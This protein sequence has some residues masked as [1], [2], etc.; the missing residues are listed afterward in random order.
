MELQADTGRNGIVREEF[1]ELNATEAERWQVGEGDSVRVECPGRELMGVVSLSSSVPAGVVAVTS[2][3]AQLA[4]ELENSQQP[5][6]MA[7][8]PGLDLVPARVVK[9]GVDKQE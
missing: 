9:T 4:V 7:R 2:L 8:V 6:P 3:F 1:V 5:V